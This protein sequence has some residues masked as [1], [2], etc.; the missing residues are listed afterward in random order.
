MQW[1]VVH[2]HATVTRHYSSARRCKGAALP[3]PCLQQPFR[4]EL[5]RGLQRQSVRAEA[6]QLRLYVLRQALR[7]SSSNARGVSDSHAQW[8]GH[9]LMHKNGR[10]GRCWRNSSRTTTT[11]NLM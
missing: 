9:V 11:M 1:P 5:F 8:E 10:E 6:L 2:A 7:R 4:L 3:L